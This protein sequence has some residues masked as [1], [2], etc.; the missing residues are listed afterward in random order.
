[1]RHGDGSSVLF[2]QDKIRQKNR[3]RV[4][5]VPTDSQNLTENVIID[6]AS[7]NYKGTINKHFQ[8]EEHNGKI[9]NTRGNSR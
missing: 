1:M 6:S 4:L 2:Y 8:N 3:P 5:F 7:I 9:S